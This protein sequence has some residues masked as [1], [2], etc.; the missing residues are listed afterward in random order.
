VPAL[1][2]VGYRL[3]RVVILLPGPIIEAENSL[4]WQSTDNGGDATG[5]DQSKATKGWRHGVAQ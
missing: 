2:R 1:I 4:N 5:N 3:V